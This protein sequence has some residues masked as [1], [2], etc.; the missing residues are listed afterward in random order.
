MRLKSIQ[1]KIAAWSGLCLLVTAAAIVGFSSVGTKN[2]AQAQR[3]EA[4]QAAK[5]IAAATAKEKA[6]LTAAQLESAMD[7]A[8]T[9]AETFSGIKDDRAKLKLDRDALN[10]IL[11]IVLE[12][13]PNF[14]ATYTAWEPNA[15]DGLDDLYK[16]TEGYDTTG[17]FVPYWAR[18]DQGEFA[19][20][21]L[22]GYETEGA[23][24]Y[25]Q[26]PKKNRTE[27]LLD[28]FVYPVQ[29]QPTLMT[30]LVV[31]IMVGDVFYGIAGIDLRLD[32]L[33][34]I[35]DDVEELYDGT[36]KIMVISH[37]GT[38]AGVTQKADLQGKPLNTIQKDVSEDL[39]L[40]QSGKSRIKTNQN[41]ELEV[42]VPLSVG[43]SQSP[44]AVK[45]VIPE[46][47]VIAAAETQMRTA[48]RNVWKMAGISVACTITALVLLWFVA[49]GIA[50]PIHRAIDGLTEKAEH[51]TFASTQISD[52]S[53]SLAEG[54]S[55]QAASIE[56][57]SS[58]LEE[59]SAMTKQNADNASQASQL[60]TGTEQIVGE[61]NGSM[62]QLT[63]SMDE[64]N[65]SS[66]ETSKIIK[67]IDEIAFQTNLLALN[68][69][70]EAARAGEAGAGFAV[71]AD[72]VRSLAMRAAEAAKNTSVLIE[73]TTQ[74]V[75]HGSAL[76]NS[77]NASFGKVTQ[78]T[79]K[80]GELIREIAAASEEQAQGI[81]QVNRAVS[82][83][84]KVVQQTAAGAEESSSASEEMAVQADEMKGLVDQIVD[85][86]DGTGKSEI[87]ENAIVGKNAIGVAFQNNPR[88]P[89]VSRGNFQPPAYQKAAV[90]PDRVIQMRNED[91]KDF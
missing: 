59:M 39:G 91:F 64:I 79:A 19:M 75:V 26:L 82:E 41:G 74:K 72:E 89:A 11:K 47:K 28:P 62:T 31:P 30:S 4:V 50:K 71:V 5:Q 29:G 20:E 21:P 9:L 7:V 8:R 86:L 13:N 49:L 17:R 48:I 18:N 36:A 34:K 45:V 25:Y 67:T 38:L 40:I 46:E 14:I 60:M 57:T 53:C 10:N 83:M 88:V 55:E 66:E 3:Q 78:S 44:W 61:A 52:S 85:L 35:A 77:T 1:M 22:L 23:G 24:D 54:A 37:N 63:K 2:A 27:C 16:G 15:L 33:Q 43:K 87:L 73:D 84:D 56:E 6:G 12:R 68:A 76:L 81:E 70:V 32:F 65:R 69:A 58:S 80:V 90:D 42:L 51:V